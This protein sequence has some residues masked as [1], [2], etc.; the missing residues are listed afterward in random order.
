MSV[1]PS[2]RQS[3]IASARRGAAAIW[4]R[5]S[6]RRAA[7]TDSTTNF[8]KGRRQDSP[9]NRLSEIE[10]ERER[11]LERAGRP[12]ERALGYFSDCFHEMTDRAAATTAALQRATSHAPSNRIGGDVI[13][14]TASTGNATAVRRYDT[15]CYF[16]QLYFTTF[17][18]TQPCIPPGSLNRVPASAGVRAGISPLS[19]CR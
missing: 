14:A 11:D 19:G 6:R 12:S 13:A 5:R 4:A 9:T 16:T 8:P 1:R 17:R 15:R 3:H 2:V 7:A 18:S 10:S